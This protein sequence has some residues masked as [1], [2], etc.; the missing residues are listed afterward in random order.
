MEEELIEHVRCRPL[1]YDPSNREYRNQNFRKEAWDEIGEKFEI[2]GQYKL[3]MTIFNNLL[4]SL[5]VSV[6]VI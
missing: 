4:N 3:I 2:S 5:I 6:V 1:L